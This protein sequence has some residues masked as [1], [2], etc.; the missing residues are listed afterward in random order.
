MAQALLGLFTLA[1]FF[2]DVPAQYRDDI[3]LIFILELISQCVEFLWYTTIVFIHRDIKTWT[4][5]I[6]WFLSTPVMLVSIAFFFRHRSGDSLVLIFEHASIYLLLTANMVMLVFGYLVEIETLTKV[7]GLLLGNVA[8]I[9]SFALLGTYVQ[10]SDAT[11]VVLYFF[12][13]G[14]WALYGVA[15][16]LDDVS[17]NVSYNILDI[18]SK[19]FYGVFITLYVLLL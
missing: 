11:S 17:K 8:F 10:G 15:A 5:Y 7:A 18:I 19:N 12:T 13:Y 9:T 4:R 14:V 6:D 2:A 1:G 3:Q 16:T